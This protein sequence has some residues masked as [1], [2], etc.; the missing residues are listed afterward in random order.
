M[1]LSNFDSIG[2]AIGAA[3][4]RDGQ[5]RYV[6]EDFSF[7]PTYHDDD[8]DGAPTGV[9][10][11]VNLLKT[12]RNAFTWTVLGTQTI[13]FP[14]YDNINGGLDIVQDLVDNDGAEYN[15]GVATNPASRG[16]FVVGTDECFVRVKMRVGDVSETDELLVGFRKAETH[17]AIYTAY[18]DYLYL[19]L[20]NATGDV[21]SES[22][23]AGAGA[24]NVDTTKDWADATTHTLEVRVSKSGVVR[25]LYDDSLSGVVQPSYTFTSGLSI[26]PSIRYL[27]ATGDVTPDPDIQ[28]LEYESGLFSERGLSH[29]LDERN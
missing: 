4:R 27:N 25:V 20:N 7:P 24:A 9:A 8:G 6:F 22:E 2:G 12:D 23:V 15:L 28:L 16:K 11:D 5:T 10:G 1:A 17:Q 3:L 21:K 26:I 14:T 29:M 13:L 19:G 18:A